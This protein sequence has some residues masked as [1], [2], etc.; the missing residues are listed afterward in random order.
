MVKVLRKFVVGLYLEYAPLKNL[1]DEM[2]GNVMKN[3]FLK[4][5]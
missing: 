2:Q 1:K 4:R 3:S 5:R